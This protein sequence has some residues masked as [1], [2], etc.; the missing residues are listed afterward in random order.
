MQNALANPKVK[1]VVETKLISFYP[2]SVVPENLILSCR[3]FS[4]NSIEDI[5][6]LE[7]KSTETAKNSGTPS[8]STVMKRKSRPVAENLASAAATKFKTTQPAR[9]SP[10]IQAV[11]AG[12]KKYFTVVYIT[13]VLLWN[14]AFL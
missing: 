13:Y 7:V 10:A 3:I 8:S 5:N 2:K 12:K 14:E 1:N 9:C 11:F 4:A 6:F